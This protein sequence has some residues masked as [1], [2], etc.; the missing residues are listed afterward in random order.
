MATTKVKGTNAKIKELKADKPEK[1]TGEDLAKLQTAVNNVNQSYLE[2]GRLSAAQHNQ[3][4][5]L[6]GVQGEITI[7]QEEMKKIYGSD[8]IN[9]QDGTIKYTEDGEADKKD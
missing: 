6:A 2:L 1:V 5:N 9:I 8:D 7:L 4:H 3:L